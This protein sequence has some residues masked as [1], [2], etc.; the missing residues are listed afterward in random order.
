MGRIYLVNPAIATAGYS[1]FTPRWLFV[2]AQATPTNLLG[3]PV[4]VDETIERFDPNNIRP[5]DIV[6]ISIS[7]GNCTSGYR[8]LRLVKQAG[9]TAIVGGIHATIFPNEPLEMGADAVVT[10]NGD[11]VWATVLKD[12]ITGRLQQRYDGGRIPGESMLKA[13]WNLLDSSKYLFP[14]VQ[15]VAGCPENCSFC[16]VWVTDGRQP[17]HRLADKVI[18]EVEELHRLGFR[19]VAFAD[20]NFAP[21]TLARIAREPSAS[22]RRELARIREERLRFFDEYAK[23]IPKDMFALTQ[24]TAEVATDDEY[25][26][27][28]YEKVGIRAALIGVESFSQAALKATNKEWNPA[29]QEMVETIAKIQRRGILVLTSLISGIE[30]DTIETLRSMREFATDSGALLAQFTFYSP[31]PGTKDF[32]EFE[33]DRKNLGKAGY[34][35]KRKAKLAYDQY[36]LQPEVPPVLIQHP[37]LTAGQIVLENTRCW[38]AFYSLPRSLKRVLRGAARSWSLGGKITYVFACLA[39]KRVYAGHGIS[40]DSVKRRKLG[41]FTKLLIYLGLSVHA[42][43]FRRRVMP[44]KVPV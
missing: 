17:R 6:G 2:M 39:F 21:A 4:L 15:T 10:G 36:W 18:E 24:M 23:A 26:T 9:A 40:A 28:I 27:A 35:P 5:G 29:G 8:I 11:L 43:F 14:S 19:H 32:Y 12:A 41:R 13:R 31:Y 37:N 33:M 16:S 34:I 7:T 1:F 42:R 44:M 25:L 3:D 22:K 30:S 38:N 20:D